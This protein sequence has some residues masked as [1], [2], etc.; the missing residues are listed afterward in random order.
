MKQS[1]GQRVL[2]FFTRRLPTAGAVAVLALIAASEAKSDVVETFNFS[3]YLKNLFGGPALAFSG[4]LDLDFS[5]DFSKYAF[6]SLDISVQGRSVFTQISSEPGLGASVASIYATNSAKDTLTLTFTTPDS[7]TWLGFNQGTI[8]M[9][10]LVFG[11][12]NG[13]YFGAGGVVTRDS[14]DPP[15]LAPPPLDPPPLSDPP[16]PVTSA[17]VPELSTWAMMLLGLAGLGLAA[18]R[19]RAIVFLAGSS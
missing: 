18:K 2:S 3:G 13:F 19:R 17:V 6:E 5:N 1:G 8:T 12:S 4:T 11:T 16:G 10:Q 14:S 9:G 7:G 15:I